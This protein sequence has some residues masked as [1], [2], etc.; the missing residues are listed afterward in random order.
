MSNDGATNG[1]AI[2]GIP[3]AGQ[4]PADGPTSL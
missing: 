2:A 3:R 1:I 4:Q